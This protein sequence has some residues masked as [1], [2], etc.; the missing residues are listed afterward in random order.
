MRTISKH[1]LDF[2]IQQGLNVLFMGQHGVGK[3]A[4]VNAAFERN[5]LRWRYF[6]AA[7]MDPW[8]D[9]IGVPKEMTNGDGQPFLELVRPKEFRDDDVEALFFDEFNRAPKK[10]RNAVMELIQFK[11]INGRKFNN[12]KI[13]WAAVNPED[14]DTYDVE[15]LDPAQADRFHIQVDVPYRCNR[16]Y[17][18]EKFGPG[19]SRPA[20]EWWDG[21]PGDERNGVSPRR[22]D[23]A[24]QVHVAG[25][26][27]R[28]VLPETSNVRKLSG[29]LRHGPLLD[30]LEGLYKAQD[31]EAAR[32]FLANENNY[33]AAIDE[34]IKHDSYEAFFLPLIPAE[35]L[36][37]LIASSPEVMQYVV[38]NVPAVAEFREAVSTLLSG[39]PNRRLCKE[40]RS[41][42]KRLPDTT[43]TQAVSAQIGRSGRLGVPSHFNTNSR[44]LGAWQPFISRLMRWSLRTDEDRSRAYRRLAD[45]L[46]RKLTTDEALS[47]LKFLNT[48]VATPLPRERLV[49]LQHLAGVVN[50][51]L[52]QLSEQTGCDLNEVQRQCGG[53]MDVLVKKLRDTGIEEELCILV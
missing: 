53:H 3:T 52:R 48:C 5:G 16:K 39:S 50:H 11:S 43:E 22:L 51:C 31:R 21:L 24:L 25:G 19:I 29:L 49:E 37:G 18:T 38:A 27:L 6:S 7:T 47:T 41:L 40:V 1:K 34:I 20:I 8:V 44:H 42:L 33:S 4:M 28:D 23:Y 13:V 17:F 15:R 35:Q 30:K 10:V 26:D 36:I 46:P 45:N 9:F 2:W 32:E 14:D 12:L